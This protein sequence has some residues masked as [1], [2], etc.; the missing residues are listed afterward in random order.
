[1]KDSIANITR[2]IMYI[3]L[4]LSVIPGV[5]FYAQLMDTELFINW[6][7]MLLIAG[8]VV[9]FISPIYG[10]I[11]NPQ[12]IVKLLVSI[13]AF[14]I[15]LGVAYSLAGNEFSAFQ[16]EKLKT[17]AD[18]SVYVGMGI[19]ATYIAFGLTVLSI[20]YASVI[21]LFK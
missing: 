12:N 2:W 1:M 4:A 9:M 15:V 5:L 3:L 19:Y 13:A 18:V 7:K 11:T 6:G 10:F 16:L 20:L 21:K 14:V 17:T 8:V